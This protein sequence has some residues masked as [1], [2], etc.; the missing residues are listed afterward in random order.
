MSLFL[1]DATLILFKAPEDIVEADDGLGLRRLA[2]VKDGRL[3]LRPH[4]AAAV[5]QETVV[6]GAHL[7][8]GQHYTRPGNK[9][10]NKRLARR[11]FM[12]DQRIVALNEAFLCV[13]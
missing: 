11:I 1:C 10:R 3:S 4:K 7:T 2:V 6:S 9:Q 8:F 13:R 5:S 12:E